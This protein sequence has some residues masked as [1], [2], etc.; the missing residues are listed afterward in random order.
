MAE[1]SK[2]VPWKNMAEAAAEEED[3]SKYCI[4]K[5]AGEGEMVGCDDP[6]VPFREKWKKQLKKLGSVKKS[7]SI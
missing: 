2:V 1:K 6:A 3:E 7:G 4:C 5:G